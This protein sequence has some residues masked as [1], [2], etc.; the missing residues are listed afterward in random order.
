MLQTFKT[1]CFYLLKEKSQT[2]PTGK[3][4]SP[5]TRRGGGNCGQDLL[6]ITIVVLPYY[7]DRVWR[8]SA[9][10]VSVTRANNRRHSKTRATWFRVIN[11]PSRRRQLASVFSVCTH[12]LV[13]A[14]AN[15][16]R[17]TAAINQRHISASFCLLSY[18]FRVLS[19]LLLLFYV[20]AHPTTTFWSY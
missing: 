5:G 7:Y 15:D 19:G 17:A 10:V 13:H 12:E 8:V 4:V 2:L 3:Y 9:G 18:Y 11:G 14:A 20:C 16:R 1:I 6:Y